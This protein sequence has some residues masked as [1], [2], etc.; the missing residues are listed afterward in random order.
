M[1][2]FQ[3]AVAILAGLAVFAWCMR[4]G[5]AVIAARQRAVLRDSYEENTSGVA[6]ITDAFPFMRRA[7]KARS[8]PKDENLA[9]LPASP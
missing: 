7:A 6:H 3:G 5:F 1:L 8:S 2:T 9:L 4:R